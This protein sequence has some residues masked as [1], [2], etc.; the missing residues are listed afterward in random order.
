MFC[1]G[2]G[3]VRPGSVEGELSTI[4]HCNTHD[5]VGRLGIDHDRGIMSGS[6]PSEWSGASETTEIHCALIRCVG[7]V[8]WCRI[9][10]GM[11]RGNSEDAT[12]E[13]EVLH[14]D[15]TWH[16]ESPYFSYLTLATALIRK[17]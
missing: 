2:S 5:L 10:N 4:N 13:S 11:K 1:K 14:L 3:V 17:L 6:K 7:C 12:T 15:P 9:G 16:T 8:R